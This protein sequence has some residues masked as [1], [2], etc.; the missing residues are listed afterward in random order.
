MSGVTGTKLLVQRELC[1]WKC[2][3]NGSVCNSKQKWKHNEYRCKCKSN[4]S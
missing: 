3:L 4:K 1:E 2:V